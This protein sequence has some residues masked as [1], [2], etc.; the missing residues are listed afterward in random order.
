MLYEGFY[1]YEEVVV[2][3]A[4]EKAMMDTGQY[5]D[6]LNMDMDRTASRS[7]Y[8]G[9]DS[10]AASKVHGVKTLEVYNVVTETEVG[11]YR[12]DTWVQ[13]KFEDPDHRVVTTMFQ[14]ET[15]DFISDLWQYKSGFEAKFVEE[16]KVR[17]CRF[18]YIAADL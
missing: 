18:D 6:K 16:Y 12:K 1:S 5:Y 7:Y 8:V 10:R 15:S 2:Y 17:K 11:Y 14:N 13:N 9:L 3:N 4:T